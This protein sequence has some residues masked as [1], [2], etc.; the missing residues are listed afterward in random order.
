MNYYE[1]HRYEKVFETRKKGYEINTES[2]I[3]IHRRRKGMRNDELEAPLESSLET[4]DKNI[5]RKEWRGF[6]SIKDT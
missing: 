4:P 3:W 5:D 6:I 1:V 2:L